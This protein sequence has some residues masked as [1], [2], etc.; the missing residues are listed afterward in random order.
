MENPAPSEWDTHY[1]VGDQLKMFMTPREI[2]SS[3]E[4]L[5]GDR[6]P[7]TEVTRGKN[8]P[9]A[10]H[11]TKR[12]YRTDGV[13][14]HMEGY[15]EVPSKDGNVTLFDYDYR[16]PSAAHPMEYAPNEN[17]KETNEQLYAR[18]YAEAAK[19]VPTGYSD[20][21]SQAK[22]FVNASGRATDASHEWRDVAVGGSRRPM[23]GQWGWWRSTGPVP[24]IP[25]GPTVNS[26][27]KEL[28]QMDNQ[29][30]PDTTRMAKSKTLAES[31]ISE[32]VLNPIRLGVAGSYSGKPQLVGGHHRMAVA[33]VHR[34]DD[35]AP[36]LYHHD[37]D[38]AKSDET[39][40]SYKYQ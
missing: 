14:N 4:P 33:R 12:T 31:I 23:T 27:R 11:F 28:V 3:W 22:K 5:E 9:R 40:R 24:G 2:E 19:A 8:D 6:Y 20:N 10:G 34:P 7:K 35:L 21:S 32:G 30:N 18:K 15:T 39:A 1:Y 38:E 13:P 36:V 29:P 25:G 17:D 16:R 26:R 37:I